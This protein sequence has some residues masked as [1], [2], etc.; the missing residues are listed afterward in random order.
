M[1]KPYAKLISNNKIISLGDVKYKNTETLNHYS[2]ILN[3][4]ALLPNN[5]QYYIKLVNPTNENFAVQ[6][7]V[8]NEQVSKYN[9][10]LNPNSEF[11]VD[12][13]ID[14]ESKFLFDG[15]DECKLL[16]INLNLQ[17]IDIKIK[18]LNNKID[19][20]NSGITNFF[21]KEKSNLNILNDEY[22]AS[23]LESDNKILEEKIKIVRN[24]ISLLENKKH[25]LLLKRNKIIIHKIN[26]YFLEEVYVNMND[27]F[28][29]LVNNIAKYDSPLPKKKNDTIF[30]SCDKNLHLNRQFNFIELDKPDITFNL[31]PE[32]FGVIYSNIKYC[33]ACGHKNIGHLLNHCSNCGTKQ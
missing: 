15:Y 29:D 1:L 19:N 9:F 32:H 27:D 3:D 33:D 20:Y 17:D 12:R 4:V 18:S 10:L 28:S 5:S 23:D 11:I 13:F 31:K 25:K 21:Q 26:I 7:I 30:N 14:K 2:D 24:E 8:N 6:I 22:D 16:S